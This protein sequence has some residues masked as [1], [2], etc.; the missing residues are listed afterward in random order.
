MRNL[1]M[2]ILM[3]SFMGCK[4]ASEAPEIVIHNAWSRPVAVHAMPADSGAAPHSGSNGVVYLEIENRGGAD[5]L[6][7]AHSEVCEVTELHQTIMSDGRMMMQL[8]EGGLEIPLRGKVALAPRGHHIMLLDMKHA[9][10]AGDSFAVQLEFE[11]SGT[12]TVFSHVQQ[13]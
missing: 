8:A 10:A 2:S 9:L 5:R 12:Q 4:S 7:R 1:L 6:L 3:M 11:K 13:P